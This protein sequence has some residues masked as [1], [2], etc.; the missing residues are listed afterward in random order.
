MATDEFRQL[1]LKMADRRRPAKR[2]RYRES[3]GTHILGALSL[4]LGIAALLRIG[5]IWRGSILIS[6]SISVWLDPPSESLMPVIPPSDPGFARYCGLALAGQFLGVAG[7]WRSRKMKGTISPLSVLGVAVCSA[8][9]SPVYLLMALW[10]VALGWP[11]I[12][13]AAAVALLAKMVQVTLR[14]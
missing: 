4:A 11:F 1:L 8:A 2:L 9:V 14:A 10:A 12:L 13:A 7:A 5:Y 6:Q 3:L